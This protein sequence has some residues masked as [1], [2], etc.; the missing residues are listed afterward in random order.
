[1][2]VRDVAV[3]FRVVGYAFLV[4]SVVIGFWHGPIEHHVGI[5]AGIT[6]VFWIVLGSISV[7]FWR[8]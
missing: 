6:G 4:F 3:V 8:R 1:M 2:T 5:A 7:I